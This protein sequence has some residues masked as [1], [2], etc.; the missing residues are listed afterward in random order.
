MARRTW[1]NEEFG[2]R[3]R[4]VASSSEHLPPPCDCRKFK[5]T[6]RS[7]PTALVVN[8]KKNVEIAKEDSRHGKEVR[9]VYEL[10]MVFE[11]PLPILDRVS[12]GWAL[13]HVIGYRHFIDLI[14]EFYQLTVDP[15][16]SPLVCSRHLDYLRSNCFVDATSRPSRA[17]L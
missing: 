11:K 7:I 2:E 9:A 5:H 15:W 13:G 3:E 10:T 14:S 6:S 17:A 8:N 16:G 12:W 1:V 4:I